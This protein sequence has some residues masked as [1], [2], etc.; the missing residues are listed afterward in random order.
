MI[1]HTLLESGGNC[2]MHV[3]CATR[4]RTKKLMCWPV[5]LVL[6]YDDQ[7]Y[8]QIIAKIQIDINNIY[9]NIN[10]NKRFRI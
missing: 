5:L 7:R 4:A 6:E 10:N 3:F 9:I 8:N 1:P 2:A